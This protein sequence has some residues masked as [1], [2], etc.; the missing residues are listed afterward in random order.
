M[1]NRQH[2][3][4]SGIFAEMLALHAIR[5]A[6]FESIHARECRGWHVPIESAVFLSGASLPQ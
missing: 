2:V 5:Y 1:A 4:Q 6:A 3:E